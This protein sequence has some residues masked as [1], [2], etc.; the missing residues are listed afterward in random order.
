MRKWI[1]ALILLAC[2][3]LGLEMYAD[4]ISNFEIDSFS[5]QKNHS[6]SL[7]SWRAFYFSS[8]CRRLIT[9]MSGACA[10]PLSFH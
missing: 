9:L 5:A 4:I 2:F 6:L 1:T 3:L 8:H 10:E 7:A